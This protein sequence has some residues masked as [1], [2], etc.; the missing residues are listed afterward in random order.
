MQGIVL[1]EH[2]D[3]WRKQLAGVPDVFEI[4]MDHPRPAR[5]TYRGAH[6]RF[7]LSAELAGQLKELSKSEGVTLFMTLM[8]AFQLLL[9]K[10][11]KQETVVVGTDVAN[12]SPTETEDL[13][14]LFINL[15]PICTV[16]SQ[17]LRFRELL[18]RVREVALAAFAHQELPFEKLVEALHPER[19]LNRNPLV[20]I[21][22]VMQNVPFEN[23]QLPGLTVTPYE[24][25]D[26]TSRFDLAFFVSEAKD[27]IKGLCV[28]SS[29]LFEQSSIVRLVHQFRRLLQAIAENPNEL[30]TNLPLNETG[31]NVTD[32]KVERLQSQLKRLKEVK[33][34]P[35]GQSLSDTI[36]LSS[37]GRD[38][39]RV[40]VITTAVSDVELPSWARLN[41]EFVEERLLHDGAVLFRGFDVNSSTE[42]EKVAL[43][44]CPELFGEYGDLPREQLEGKVYGATPYPADSAI[45]FHNESS[46]MHRWP[47]KIWFLC[48]TPPQSGGETPL[49]DCRTIYNLLDPAIRRRLEEKK[50][51]YVRNYTSGLDV[52]WQSFF[53]TSDRAAVEDYC[54]GAGS[55]FEWKNGNGLRTRQ[56]CPAIVRHPQTG[57][58]T[59]FNQ[60]QLHHVACL[61][62]AVREALLS[63]L[64]LE[65]LPRN[66][67]YGDGSPIEDSVVAE[68]SELYRSNCASFA[69]QRGD[70]LMLNNMLVAHA[71][72]PYEGERKIVVAMGEMI[73][74]SEIQKGT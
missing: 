5:P 30:L 48:V 61:E 41:K 52:S 10:L 63:T 20:Q 55:E 50:L 13:I 74:Q 69:W 4:P 56:V 40:T 14:G 28:Y 31:K 53:R 11:S 51:M 26:E 67:Y 45:L 32:R 38:G 6:E 70:V 16:V 2:L 15:A 60:I 42:F 33:R 49:V 46:H 39:T 8:A 29:D 36:T 19:T 44:L 72:N 65:D 43:A 54:R 34:K 58:P 66:V 22:F 73:E 9:A 35:L 7:E 71:R 1:V 25:K 3:F 47:M 17:N 24:L 27:K 68:I 18:R 62:P 59:F 23:L 37:L 12:R 64:R 21:L 57:E